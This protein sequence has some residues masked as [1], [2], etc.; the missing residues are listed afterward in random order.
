MASLPDST[1]AIEPVLR[2]LARVRR[3]ARGWVWIESLAILAVAGAAVVW[4]TLAIDWLIEPPAWAR[5]AALATAAGVAI[6]LVATRLVGRL[7]APLSDRALALAIERRQPACGDALSTAVT[8]REAAGDPVD[9]ELARR[10][11]AT[12]AALAERTSPGAVFRRGRLVGVALFGLLAAVSV[13]GLA[14][15]APAI[16]SLWTR[17]MVLLEDVPWPRRVRLEA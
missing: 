5:G 17:R 12:A 3:E 13:A 11:T 8:L 14:A 1:A 4:G 9:P 15:A 2:L 16:A 6:W 10:T 7:A